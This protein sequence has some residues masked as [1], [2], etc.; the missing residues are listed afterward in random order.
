MSVLILL[1]PVTNLGTAKASETVDASA[2]MAFDANT[3]QVI[4]A[5]DPAKKVAIGSITKIITLYLVTQAIKDGKISESDQLTPTL[6]QS[7]MTQNDE[8]TNVRLD[9][10]KAYTV[11]DLYNAAWI[12]SSNSAAMMLA[13]K[14]SGDQ[15]SFVKLMRKTLKSWGIK[16]AEINNVSGLNNSDL[17]PGM[18]LGKSDAENKLS[19]NDIAIIA[20]HILNKY[21]E[22]LKTTSQQEL[23]FPEGSETKTYTSLNLL[24]NGNRDY[25]QGY[26][27]DGLK[28]G[29]TK[30]AGDSFVGTLPMDNSRIVTIVMNAS[31]DDNDQDKRFR[32]TQNLAK[33][34]K[35]NF[36]HKKVLTKNQ[37][38]KVAHK[39]A[40]Y[41]NLD[42]VYIWLPKDFNENSL[43]YN[44]SNTDLGFKTKVN[45]KSV[46][47]IAT[48]TPDGYLPYPKE[49]VVLKKVKKVQKSIW[50]QI[51]EFF[52]NLF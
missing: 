24:L 48:N 27:F 5:K 35:E 12:V 31:G 22:I 18:Y 26:E 49:T 16:D 19:V 43:S 44:V 33:Y 17:K 50:H 41:K 6:E 30:Q 36:V 29:T 38:I 8:L 13:Q 34:V 40:E 28:T 9:T 4:Y 37:K 14:V 11:K 45:N 20:K 42:D 25:Q 1:I 32:A 3:G 2:A 51:I 10:D 23:V 52:D 21:P 47:L 39:K 46:K 15:K 7:E